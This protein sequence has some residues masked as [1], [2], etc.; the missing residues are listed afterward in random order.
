MAKLFDVEIHQV[1]TP[2]QTKPFLLHHAPV[3]WYEVQE[4]DYFSL[5]TCRDALF[6]RS[7]GPIYA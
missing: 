7:S 3:F 5:Q 6:S 4:M 2:F 1:K